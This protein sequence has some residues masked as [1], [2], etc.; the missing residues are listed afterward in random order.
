MATTDGVEWHIIPQST[1]LTTQ[2]TG[3][4]TGFSDVWEVNY[5]IDSGPATGVRGHVNIPAAQ[6]TPEIAS[7]AIAAQVKLLHAVHSL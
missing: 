4:G 1:R 6:F 2:L 7:A 3:V 5:Q